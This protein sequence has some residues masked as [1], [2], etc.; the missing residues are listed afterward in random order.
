MSSPSLEARLV[1][2]LSD[3]RL[4]HKLKQYRLLREQIQSLSGQCEPDRIDA[5]TTQLDNAVL[6]G[7]SQCFICA[8]AAANDNP[9]SSSHKFTSSTSAYRPLT[10]A[11]LNNSTNLHNNNLHN[12]NHSLAGNG[13]Y[14]RSV[15]ASGVR[16]FPPVNTSGY[17]FNSQTSWHGGSSTGSGRASST[18][19]VS[20][21]PDSIDSETGSNTSLLSSTTSSS[22]TTMT[23]ESFEPAD[24]PEVILENGKTFLFV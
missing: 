9:I 5:L 15:S 4:P 10:G 3:L 16:Q 20:P 18:G 6:C 8:S 2:E 23:N 21:Q 12:S 17:L 24:K 19:S 11:K 1:R 22:T 13:L 7:V 14:N